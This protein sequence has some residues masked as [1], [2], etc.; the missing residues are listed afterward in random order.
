MTI[1]GTEMADHLTSL[2]DN[3]EYVSITHTHVTVPLNNINQMKIRKILIEFF[4]AVKISVSGVG[5]KNIMIL[6]SS[7][8]VA[9]P[10]I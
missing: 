8:C 4:F 5:Q 1:R 3:G 9:Y 10:K 7:S 6:F 2:S